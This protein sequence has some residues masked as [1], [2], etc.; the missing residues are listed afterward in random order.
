MK[1]KP[2]VW[3]RT[4]GQYS[5]GVDA[6]IEHIKIGSVSWDSLKSRSSNDGDYKAYFN[7]PGYKQPPRNFLTEEDGKKWLEEIFTIW[8]NKITLME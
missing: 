2:I 1:L 5:N 3:T 7:L 6:R 8:I 4:S